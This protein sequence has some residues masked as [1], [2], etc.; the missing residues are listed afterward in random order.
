MVGRDSLSC[1][2]IVFY[3]FPPQRLSSRRYHL[4]MLAHDLLRAEPYKGLEPKKNYYQI[5]NL[6]QTD[7]KVGHKVHRSEEVDQQQTKEQLRP[8]GNTAITKQSPEEF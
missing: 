7:Q 6:A 3:F 4:D 2:T 1:P 5:I 8:R